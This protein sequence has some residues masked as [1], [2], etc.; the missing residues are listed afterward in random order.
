MVI[1]DWV[2]GA[3]RAT[4]EAFCYKHGQ[5]SKTAIFLSLATL[6]L[7][8]LWVFQSLFAGVTFLGWW[9]VP[10]F[11]SGAAASVMG[12]LA[13]LYLVNHSKLVRGEPTVETLEEIRNS[14]DRIV[15]AV[16]GED[17]EE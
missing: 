5:L 14:M 8:F 1:F 11:S 12:V 7:L 2:R 3:V 4:Y 15:A 10:A 16:K 17:E 13:S 6:I 9:I